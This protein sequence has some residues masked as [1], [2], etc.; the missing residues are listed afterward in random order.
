[1]RHAEKILISCRTIS[2]R[3][4]AVLGRGSGSFL[5]GRWF[6]RNSSL[7]HP[8]FWYF[9]TL[10]WSPF[11]LALLSLTGVSRFFPGAVQLCCSGFSYLRLPVLP[12]FDQIVAVPSVFSKAKSSIPL[13]AE[14]EPEKTVPASKAGGWNLS[15]SPVCSQQ[16]GWLRVPAAFVDLRCWEWHSVLAVLVPRL[17][18]RT[19]FSWRQYLLAVR[20]L[21]S[22]AAEALLPESAPSGLAWIWCLW[23]VGASGRVLFPVT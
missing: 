8:V 9:Q 5:S 12:G 13:V 15:G 7:T 18:A 16:F 23:T 2:Y 22:S 17:S 10:V 14:S 19:G 6:L 11:A 1:M 4:L 21:R 3:I 20:V